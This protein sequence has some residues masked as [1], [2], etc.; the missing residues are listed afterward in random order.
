MNSK[1]R[2][3]DAD[4]YFD[5]LR[6]IHKAIDPN[7]AKVRIAMLDSGI[8]IRHP[9]MIKRKE[10]GN[11]PLAK[12][13]PDCLKPLEDLDG[14]GTHGASVLFQTVPNAVLLVARV[15]NDDGIMPPVNNYAATAEVIGLIL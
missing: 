2:A 1:Y 12:G 11:I 3:K 13:F 9:E 15:F 10:N 8:N 6:I 5:R 4:V 14:H 7:N